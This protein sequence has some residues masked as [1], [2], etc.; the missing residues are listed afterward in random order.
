MVS[1]H[2]H[3]IT[4]PF[5]L[6]FLLSSTIIHFTPFFS[7]H[8]NDNHHNQHLSFPNSFHFP[9]SPP[10]RISFPWKSILLH[11]FDENHP[12]ASRGRGEGKPEGREERKRAGLDTV[13]INIEDYEDYMGVGSIIEKLEKEKLKDTG[14]NL[15]FYKEPTDSDT[16]DGDERFTPDAIKKR[17]DK[18]EKKFKRDKFEQSNSGSARSIKSLEKQIIQGAVLDKDDEEEL[19]DMKEKD[20]ILLEKLNAIDK[21]LEEK[22]V[23][24]DHTFRKKGKLLEE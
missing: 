12:R 7:D 13:D 2:S 18:F 22:L 20:D 11:F 10:L 3:P 5:L 24:L 4:T 9:F 17:S 14:A 6:L 1:S 8:P 21:K 15:N 19:N 16:D 23:E